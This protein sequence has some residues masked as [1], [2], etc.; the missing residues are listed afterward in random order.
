L[1]IGLR[2]TR[3]KFVSISFEP[4]AVRLKPSLR[5]RLHGR[6]RLPELALTLSLGTT[7]LVLG[8]SLFTPASGNEDHFRSEAQQMIEVRSA[9][10]GE[11]AV[12]VRKD[13]RVIPLG[14][15]DSGE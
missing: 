11:A 2:K 7:A 6:S 10:T 8:A 12:P 5:V 14:R 4:G 13:V 9:A 3:G 1:A 15:N